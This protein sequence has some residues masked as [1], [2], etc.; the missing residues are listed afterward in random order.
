M[1]ECFSKIM[2]NI[3]LNLSIIIDNKIRKISNILNDTINIYNYFYYKLV[4]I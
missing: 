2:D 4:M 3:I 1:T